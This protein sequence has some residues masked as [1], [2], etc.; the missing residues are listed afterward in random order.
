MVEKAILLLN[1]KVDITCRDEFGNTV[2]HTLLK[3]ERCYRRVHTTHKSWWGPLFEAPKDLL[4]VFITAGADVYATNDD[5]ETPS[6]IAAI[7]GREDEWIYSLE[8]CGYEVEEVFASCIHRPTSKRQTSKL[9]FQEYCQLRQSSSIASSGFLGRFEEADE[10]YD[11][12]SQHDGGDDD[13]G[14]QG[15]G[16]DDSLYGG[17]DA[18]EEDDDEEIGVITD[19]TECVDEGGGDMETFDGAEPAEHGTNL[20]LDKAGNTHV[21]KM[22][23]R[24]TWDTMQW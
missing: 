24:S 8:L 14:V 18:Y 23:E 19:N 1:R 2:L 10:D 11:E 3:S 12:N 22:E 13:D 15:E 17:E 9:S 21:H 16:G 5:G 6:M 7:Y 4:M 20:G